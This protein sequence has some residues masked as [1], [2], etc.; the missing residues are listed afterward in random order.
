MKKFTIGQKVVFTEGVHAIAK[1][2]CSLP[3]TK[4]CYPYGKS[5]KTPAYLIWKIESLSLKYPTIMRPI[6][7]VAETG[8]EDAKEYFDKERAFIERNKKHIG[9]KGN[10]KEDFDKLTSVHKKLKSHLY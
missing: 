6:G 2:I 8:L 3:F 10:S 1:I 4:T 7:I 9:E 5:E